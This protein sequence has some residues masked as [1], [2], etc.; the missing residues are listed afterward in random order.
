MGY[1]EFAN[2]H[3]PQTSSV[4]F[5]ERGAIILFQSN[6]FFY[7]I[8]TLQ[9]NHA[10]NGGALLSIESKL[11]IYGKV[12]IAYNTATRNGGDVYLSNS[13]LNC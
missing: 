12:T 13:E 8:C 6:A 1:V 11:Y 10:E 9:N 2:N 7:G 4:N 3:P 5:H